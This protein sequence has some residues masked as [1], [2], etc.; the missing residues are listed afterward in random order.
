VDGAAGI[1]FG[2]GRTRLPARRRRL[3]LAV[4]YAA[5]AATLPYL[6]LKAL[7]VSGGTIGMADPAFFADPAY[8]AGNLVTMGM[9]AVVVLLA[10]AFT[11]AGGSACRPGWCCS[12]CGSRPAS[13]SPS[14]SCCPGLGV[15]EHVGQRPQPPGWSGGQP[16]GR[17]A[18]GGPRRRRG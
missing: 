15:G 14:R 11:L 9:D 4:G 13:W 18:A 12:R 3:R 6:T 2:A 5:V 17:P 1:P 10:L 8:L 16:R 7:W